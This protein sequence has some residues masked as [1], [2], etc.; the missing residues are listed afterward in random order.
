MRR[1]NRRFGHRP[2]RVGASVDAAVLVTMP[3]LAACGG[4]SSTASGGSGGTLVIAMTAANLP[5]TTAGGF[6]SEGWEGERFVGFQ[7]YDGL[8]KYD[9]SSS[10]TNPAVQPDLA[11]SW[12]V[13]T[14]HQTWTFKLRPNVKFQDGTPWNAD[15][16]VFGFDRLMNKKSPYYDQA[17]AGLLGFYD[18]TI[19][20]YKKVDDMTFAITTHTPY[21][22]LT[23][24]LP[25]LVFP[26][27]T[28]VKKDGKSFADHPVGTGPF[29]MVSKVTG[30]SLT[31]VPNPDYWAGP[32][33]VAK[34]IL[35]PIPDATARVAALRSGDVNW[36]EF[37]TP[38]DVQPLKD[39]GFN[40]FENPYS[41]LWPWIF[42]V[43]KG[44]LKD[45][46]VRQAL[47]YAIDRQS[48][49]T[50]LLKGTGVAA[51]QYIPQT[52]IGY[53]KANDALTNDP[54]KAKQLLTE[55]GY[56]NGFSMTLAYP[57]SGS[58]NM[59]PGPMNEFL[60]AE[61]AQIGVKV[62]LIPLEWSTLLSDYYAGKVSANANAVC[63][64][65]G[66]LPQDGWAVYFQSDSLFNV[67]HLKD[68]VLDSLLRTAYSTFDR[69]K[70]GAA[71]DALN[72]QLMKDMPWLVVVSDNN[73]RVLARSVHGFVQPRAVWVDL[74]KLTVS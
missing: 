36:A 40:V 56:P 25:F 51:G 31:M 37:P 7:L 55:A 59:I 23:A 43:T 64:S 70:Q 20:S 11:E 54:A 24:D 30:Q 5:G 72:A 2:A 29:K 73:P 42:D 15:A 44:P 41:H 71:F 18:T 38:D 57:T 27:P 62:K 46:R 32:A 66:F 22:Y 58:G 65:L 9:L 45:A 68:P 53:T 16:A 19:A 50:N 60:Q 13:S 67:G 49:V 6:E 48:M 74:T 8:T 3:T 17:D 33:K 4:T 21:A 1:L 52:D 26:S 35:R 34:V 28:A 14:D 63:I 69:A 61:L 39:A 10:T 12:T 47:N